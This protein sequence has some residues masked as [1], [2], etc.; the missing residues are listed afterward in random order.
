MSEQPQRSERSLRDRLAQI[1]DMIDLEQLDGLVIRRDS[2]PMNPE[3]EQPR[4]HRLFMGL[5]QDNNQNNQ[6]QPN[7]PPP[8]NNEVVRQEQEVD[9]VFAPFAPDFW[10]EY[11]ILFTYRNYFFKLSIFLKS[12]FFRESEVQSIE[13]AKWITQR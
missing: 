5:E 4:L 12:F 7:P 10:S 13:R 9:V 6:H 8:L 3:E 1:A 2:V 11:R